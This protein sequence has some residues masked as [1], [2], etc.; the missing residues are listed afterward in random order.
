MVK[1]LIRLML[2]GVLMF[3]MVTACAGP[4]PTGEEAKQLPTITLIPPSGNAGTLVTI[5]GAGF[6]PGEELKVWLVTTGP[7]MLVGLREKIDGQRLERIVANELGT[8]K[9]ISKIPR[10]Q[11]TSKGVYAIEVTGDKGSFVVSPVEVT[12]E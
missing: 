6:V 11:V 7:P 9:I 4:T 8:F 1:N 5:I 3:G 12:E 10:T 2:A